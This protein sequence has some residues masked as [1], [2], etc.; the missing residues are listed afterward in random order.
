MTNLLRRAGGAFRL[1]RWWSA[2]EFI[3]LLGI[4][5]LHG[6]HSWQFRLG[7]VREHQNRLDGAAQ[8]YREAIA[9]A[10]H[11]PEYHLRLGRVRQRQG[12]FAAAEELYST[13]ISHC[14]DHAPWLRQRARLR[15]AREDWSG[16]VEDYCVL[17]DLDPDSKKTR[18][19]LGK[20]TRKA[21][22]PWAAVSV[23]RQALEQWDEDSELSRK[24]A[25]S[26][27]AGGNWSTACE[28]LRHLLHTQ[29][30]H[31]ETSYRMARLLDRID[32]VAFELD[33]PDTVVPVAS[34]QRDSG[35]GAAAEARLRFEAALPPREPVR[36]SSLRRFVIG[37]ARR[38]V[39][40]RLAM[41]VPRL[42]QRVHRRV[43]LPET[44]V[45]R[46]FELG[47]LYER[48]GRLAEAVQ[49]Y[50]GA[51]TALQSVDS[52][53]VHKAEPE[54]RFRLAYAEH[55]LGTE[56]TESDEDVRLSRLVA[57][58]A[59]PT[60]A[61][62]AEAV[63]QSP[64]GGHVQALVQSTGL[65]LEG[66]LLPQS[67]ETIDIHL[68]GRPVKQVAA[69]PRQ[70]LRTFNFEFT[71]RVLA[72]FPEHSRLTVWSGDRLVW[73]DRGAGHLDITVPGGS[74][75][76][77]E[78][79]ESGHSIS[80][81]GVL[82]RPATE[83]ADRQMRYLKAYREARDQFEEVLG[84]KL[85]LLYGTL[86][87][88]YRDGAFIAGDDDFDVAYV[89]TATDPSALKW[90]L[91]ENALALLRAGYDIAI[92]V[93]GRLF[94][95]RLNEIWLDINPLWFHN[96]RAWSFD[97]HDLS[98]D[99]VEPVRVMDFMEHRVYVPNNIE[100]FLRD[101]YGD[102]WHVPDPGFR[103]YRDNN[104]LRVLRRSWLTPSEAREF[105]RLAEAE[106]SRN[107]SAGRYVGI[108]DPADTGFTA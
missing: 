47:T 96:G 7:Q 80:K 24:L 63:D 73:A 95:L 74:G 67:P 10:P 11:I 97:V 23:Y 14:P 87:G 58:A 90:E 25:E 49:T 13:A 38:R 42:A 46:L 37:L 77:K 71:H 64:P 5:H 22:G 28:V 57:P 65:R 55:Q 84:K 35:G 6:G 76:L 102:Q 44:R 40:Y 54:W 105:S 9:D 34:D 72:E 100:A 29:H 91:R 50:R 88:C 60:R 26:Y 41:R 93:S 61:E 66:F 86:L 106:R 79:L 59:P 99:D 21:H 92:T 27:E 4:R 51:V 43:A 17:R 15:E 82:A 108:G 78:L 68:D 1:L 70:W 104:V 12:E 45:R 8:A 3:Y 19:A 56:Q 20:A 31:A 32:R 33:G 69:N 94:K 107:P 98:L 83:V 85:F 18:L 52:I 16:A 36:V 48:Q 89:S 2:A 39:L 30:R 101:N 103:Y 53:W 75:R 62:R 81:K